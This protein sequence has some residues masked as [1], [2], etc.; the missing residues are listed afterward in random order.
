VVGGYPVLS[1]EVVARQ[2]EQFR[3]RFCFSAIDSE[4]D[5]AAEAIGC[6][7][8]APLRRM[9]LFMLFMSNIDNKVRWN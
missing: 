3:R 5:R 1:D 8:M 4:L 9:A 6:R 2:F 7:S